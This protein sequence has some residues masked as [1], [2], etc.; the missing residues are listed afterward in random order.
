MLA[1]ASAVWRDQ[2][3]P[4]PLEFWNL[5]TLQRISKPQIT[6]SDA[7]AISF[8][9]H[10]T[11][12]AIASTDGTVRLWDFSTGTLLKKFRPHSDVIYKPRKSP[13]QS[14]CSSAPRPLGPNR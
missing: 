6:T 5:D 11:L 12:L 13:Q 2:I 9:H 7:N 4:D 8:A 1:A 14:P 3:V 10:G